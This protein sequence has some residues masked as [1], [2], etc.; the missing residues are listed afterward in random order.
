MSNDVPLWLR[1]LLRT[2][3]ERIRRQYVKTRSKEKSF[4][5]GEAHHGAGDVS[6]QIDVRPEEIV[7]QTFNNA[8]E[9]VVVICEGLGRNVFPAW[10]GE[11]EAAWCVI[12]DPL[13]GSREISYKKRSAWV[14]SGVAPH[15][16]RRRSR[17][18]S[19]RSRLRC[20]RVAD[21]RS[22]PHRESRAAGRPGVL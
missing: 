6:F 7:E 18:S 1:T 14:L 9:A 11:G 13:D 16:R 5:S 15:A 12:V 21:D 20:R 10:A 22:G 4:L 8:P 19:G 3:H 2:M 17:T